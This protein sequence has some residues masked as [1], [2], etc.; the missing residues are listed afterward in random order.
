[1]TFFSACFGK[2]KPCYYEEPF[3]IENR[4][5]CKED[6]YVNVEGYFTDWARP[7]RGFQGTYHEVASWNDAHV[8]SKIVGKPVILPWNLWDT[9]MFKLDWEQAEDILYTME[10]RFYSEGEYV[11]FEDYPKFQDREAKYA[12]IIV[13]MGS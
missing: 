10:I 13:D 6:E 3:T 9:I 12:Y 8:M 11:R 1:M 4:P 2:M 5:A 7:L